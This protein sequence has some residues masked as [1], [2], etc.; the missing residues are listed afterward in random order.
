MV[1][2]GLC[3][4]LLYNDFGNMYLLST[5]GESIF[6]YYGTYQLGRRFDFS[7]STRKYVVYN[8]NHFKNAKRYFVLLQSV[9]Y[10]R[11][12]YLLYLLF[13]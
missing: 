9:H 1:L 5:S 7:K 3:N 4:C 12:V 10:I 13:I 2:I 8:L 6:T 11:L